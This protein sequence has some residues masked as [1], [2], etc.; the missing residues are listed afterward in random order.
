MENNLGLWLTKRAWLNPTREAY[1][2]DQGTRLTFVEL[3]DRCNRIAN[4]FRDAGIQKQE[5]VGLLLMNSAEFME[6]YFALG[7]I[8]A[9]V[10]PLNWYVTV[11]P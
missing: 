3:N 8:G 1:V 5:R 6:A 2:D 9:V 10:V 4:A 7:K 11:P